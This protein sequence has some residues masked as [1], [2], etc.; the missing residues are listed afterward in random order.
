MELFAK[1]VNDWKLLTILEESFIS[2]AWL[3]SEYVSQFKTN[4]NKKN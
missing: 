3:D 2:D 4:D 1:I